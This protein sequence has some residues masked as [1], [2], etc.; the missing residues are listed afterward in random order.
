[1][2]NDK[3][4]ITLESFKYY[5]NL[6][7]RKEELDMEKLFAKKIE[8][9]VALENKFK[10]IYNNCVIK[11]KECIKYNKYDIIY[12]V[13]KKYIEMPDYKSIDCIKYIEKNL[14]KLN[15]QIIIVNDNKMYITW[16]KPLTKS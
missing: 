9:K 1:M 7:I 4:N 12:T 10:Q 16:E 15:F 13:P 5:D 8:H 2:N 14:A 6:K 11:I 3:K